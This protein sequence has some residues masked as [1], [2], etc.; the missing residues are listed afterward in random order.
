MPDEIIVRGAR[1]HNLK[2]I[3]VN[4]PLGKFV[5]VA[6]VSGSGKS[7]LAL[8]VLYAEGSRR[9]L[10]A[11]SAYTRRRLSQAENANVDSIENVP[12][13][14]ALHQRPA[15][16]NVRSTFGT[17]TELSNSLRLMYSRLGSHL[18]PNGHFV[19]PTMNV[20]AG[21][22]LVCPVCGAIFNPP[23]AEDFSFNSTGA[24]PTCSGTGI[25]RKVNIDALVPDDSLTI[26]E[27]FVDVVFDDGR[28]PRD[29]RAD[30]RAVQGADGKRK[31][32]RV[33]RTGGEETYFLSC[34]KFESGGGTGFYVFQRRLY[35]GK[36][37]G[38][39][40]RRNGNEA[41]GEVS[42]GNDLP[43]LRRHA[44]E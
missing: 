42:L 11:L 31:R 35:R 27:E 6:G 41:R 8:G 14:L 19:P 23:A 26:D 21:K 17:L 37:A 44:A 38:E 39:S 7:S 16:P 18:C 32:N 28:L 29:G 4:I 10:E 25:V 20:A 12:A 36:R 40:E 3:D 2:N 24:C 5:A 30:G 43:G 13:A 1:V 22:A 9:Y 15:V 33:S 34:E